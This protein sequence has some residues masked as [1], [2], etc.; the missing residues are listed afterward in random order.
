MKIIETPRLVLR[1]WRLED[2]PAL[3]AYA[4]NPNVGPNAGWKPHESLEESEKIIREL[5]LPSVGEEYVWAIV[6][7]DAGVPCGSFGLEE[8]GRRPGVPSCRSLGYVLG[9]EQWGKGYMTEAARAVLRFGFEE[10]GLG[11]ITVNH[12]A[13][14]RRSRRVI[15]KCGFYYEG[16]LRQ[17]ARLYDGAVLDLCCYSMTAEEYRAQVATWQ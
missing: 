16:T 14:N 1:P 17:G 8:D 15:E 12:F 5:F 3:Y 7:K 6:P 10:Q 11:L 9:E 4:K 13:N 2:A